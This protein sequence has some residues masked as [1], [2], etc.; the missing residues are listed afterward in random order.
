MFRDSCENRQTADTLHAAAT[1]LELCQIW[2]PLEPDLASRIKF[3]KYHAVRIARAIKAGEDPNLSNPTVESLETQ[4][5]S[6]TPS[7]NVDSPGFRNIQDTE[8]LDHRSRQPFVEEIP[9]GHDQFEPHHAQESLINQSLHSFSAHSESRPQNRDVDRW[10]DARPPEVD[11]YYAQPPPSEKSPHEPPWTSQSQSDGGEY[12]PRGARP[13]NLDS[14]PFLPEIPAGNP[15]SIRSADLPLTSAE[16]SPQAPSRPFL[17]DPDRHQ[18]R[19]L[20]S[21]PPLQINEPP[22]PEQTHA[23]TSTSVPQHFNGPRNPPARPT[24]PSFQQ[25]QLKNQGP[26]SS[27]FHHGGQPEVPNQAT[28][29]ADEEAIMTAQKHARWAISALNF[30]DVNTAIKELKGAL[31]ALGVR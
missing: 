25:P 18:P 14:V 22:A 30:E 2:G 24:Q 17:Q 12:F 27:G 3:A 11:D 28:F 26:A 29:V 6:F 1:F 23:P 5:H 4:E 16:T 7:G 21:F 19:S 20:E 13:G 10:H 15:G 31:E 9:D 8:N